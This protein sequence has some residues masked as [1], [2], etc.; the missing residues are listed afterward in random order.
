MAVLRDDACM[1]QA[2][3]AAAADQGAEFERFAGQRGATC[4]QTM[5]TIVPW[6]EL[7]EVIEPHYPKAGR[8]RPPIGLERMLRMY[9][10][11]HWFNRRRGLRGG[12][13]G[14]HGAAP[15]RGH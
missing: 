14:Q 1:K 12:A 10:V 6:A 5:D 2:T 9:F 4:S 11:Q 15:L 7:C 3:L 13:A 8:G